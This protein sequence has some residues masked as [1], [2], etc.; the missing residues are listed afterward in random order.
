MLN[1]GKTD[2]YKGIFWII[3]P[4]NVY[5]SKNYCF[6]IPCDMNGNNTSEIQL[7]SNN[8]ETFNHERTWGY[9]EKKQTFGQ[10]YNYFPRGRVEISNGKATIYLNPNINTEE[11]KQFIIDEFHLYKINGIS[12]VRT[13]SDGSDHYKCFLDT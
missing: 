2:L 13:V 1:E 3:D 7:N 12:S 10:K 6:C 9:L 4:D 8:G 5:A 11:V